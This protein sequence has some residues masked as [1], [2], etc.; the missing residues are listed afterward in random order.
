METR[1]FKPEYFPETW[2]PPT[3]T[4][5]MS[6]LASNSGNG[7]RMNAFV[8][9]AEFDAL[10]RDTMNLRRAFTEFLVKYALP[11]SD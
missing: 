6:D 11:N 9:R 3:G 2:C 1:N 10:R 5:W 8:T 7:Q 4:D